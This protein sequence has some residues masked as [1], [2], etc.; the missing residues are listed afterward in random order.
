[1]YTLI[2]LFVG[3]ACVEWFGWHPV[4][5]PL[6]CVFIGF[7]IDMMRATRRR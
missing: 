4:L 5:V 1:M 3:L 7:G 6:G 2:G